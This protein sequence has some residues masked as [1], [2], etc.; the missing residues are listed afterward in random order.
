[1]SD[2][3]LAFVWPV[4][5]GLTLT[6]I[7]ERFLTPTPK[8]FWLRSWTANLLHLNGWLIVFCFELMLF[9]R[10]WFAASL[11]TSFFALL[12]FVN[13]AK[14][15]VL[16]EPFIYQDFEYFF[17]AIKHPRLYIP[18]F[19]IGKT[20]LGVIIFCL[21][22]I[23]GVKL[24]PSVLNAVEPSRFWLVCSLIVTICCLIVFLGSSKRIDGLSFRPGSDLFSYGLFAAL[25]LYAWAERRL[26]QVK[27]H[28]HWPVKEIGVCPLVVAVQSESF[29]DART[30]SPEIRQDVLQHFDQFLATASQYGELTTPAWGANTVRSEF[31]F[32]SGLSP[33][34][35][36]V[37]QF[38]P[39][40]KLA[41]QSP[42]TLARWFKERGYRTI[43]IHPYYASFYRRSEV[44]PYLGFDE[45]IDIASF[46]SLEPDCPYV[47]DLVL[48]DQVI[49]QIDANKQPTFIFVITMENHGPLHLEKVGDEDWAQLY[50]SGKQ[51]EGCQDLTAYL[52]HLRNAD[53]MVKRLREYLVSMSRPAALCWYGDHVPV[54]PKV[55]QTY[56]QPAG[57]TP[58]AIWGNVQSQQG[59]AQNLAAHELGAAL[60]NCVIKL[61]NQSN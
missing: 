41:K 5:S 10:P 4:L 3:L 24:E 13:N 55:Y 49:A 17:D 29:F 38:N 30:L 46:P 28:A 12:V 42:F 40:R 27:V 33:E 26:H 1:V 34:Q 25:Q 39:Y 21:L 18:F 60:L 37:H 44:Y 47:T 20:L 31:A 48:T 51:P 14:F 6:L 11:A 35:L 54:M 56:G 15:A 58:Y 59:Q 32:L 43:C 8:P 9:Q 53:L 19:G 22:L 16:R 36:G 52:R 45:F 23:A 61:S 57:Q 50:V 2:V 7:F